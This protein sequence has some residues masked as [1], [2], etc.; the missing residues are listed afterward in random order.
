M[1]FTA[2]CDENDAAEG[3]AA[4]TAAA[5]I[6]TL[7]KYA[8]DAEAAAPKIA[9]DKPQLRHLHR[10]KMPH[11]TQMSHNFA[12]AVGHNSTGVGK[13]CNYN[14]MLQMG[15]LQPKHLHWSSIPQMTQL[16]RPQATT[17]TPRKHINVGIQLK[18][19]ELYS[20]L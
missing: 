18:Q 4:D 13:Q 7:G 17:M 11:M 3:T 20:L 14:N 2:A 6:F 12:A 15:L 9:A 19:A 16:R 8:T 10:S 5:N 1:P